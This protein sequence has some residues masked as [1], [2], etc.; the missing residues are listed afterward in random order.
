MKRV[1]CHIFYLVFVALF[2]I[3]LLDIISYHVFLSH[4]HLNKQHNKKLRI[5]NFQALMVVDGTEMLAGE[6]APLKWF[7]P[8]VYPVISPL[9]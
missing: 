9:Y 4:A 1:F 2:M 7:R 5:P 3:S 6:I 8:R